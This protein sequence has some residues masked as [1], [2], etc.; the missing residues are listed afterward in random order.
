MKHTCHTC[1]HQRG[2]SK[3]LDGRI[4][5]R[6]CHEVVDTDGAGRLT[7][8]P[9]AEARRD[10]RGDWWAPHFT[11]IAGEIIVKAA[12]ALRSKRSHGESR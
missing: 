8:T 6:T 10:C 1:R 9:I 12:A 3:A 4:L 5:I 2:P 7:D 11:K